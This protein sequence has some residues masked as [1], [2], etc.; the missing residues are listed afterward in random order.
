[1]S[2]ITRRE[3]RSYTQKHISEALAGKA[4]VKASANTIVFL[5]HSHYDKELIELTERLL[6]SHGVSIYIDRR[7]P[8]LRE[9]PSFKTAR[10]IKERIVSTN[11][12]IMIASDRDGISMGSMGIGL[13]RWEK[14]AKGY[15]GN[16]NSG[17]VWFLGWN[18]IYWVV[19]NNRIWK[20]LLVGI[21]ANYSGENF[22]G[23]M[24]KGHI[25]LK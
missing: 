11:K 4:Y 15:S 3:L 12:F 22:I 7:D 19:S 14:T 5:S 10:I 1:M 25:I 20:Y 13:C 17:N 18:G 16:T 9:P 24:V 23:N 2:Y 8:E 21:R 6:T